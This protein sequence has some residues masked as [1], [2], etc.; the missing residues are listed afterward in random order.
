MNSLPYN[1]TKLTGHGKEVIA[2]TTFS[3]CCRAVVKFARSRLIHILLL[4]GDWY[5]PESFDS[6]FSLVA[7]NAVDFFS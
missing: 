7:S 4:L 6:V 2:I 5:E 1:I 3:S